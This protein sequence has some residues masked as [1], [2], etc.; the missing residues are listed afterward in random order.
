MYIAAGSALIVLASVSACSGAS[1]TL[2][3][4]KNGAPAPTPSA[5]PSTPY[6]SGYTFGQA[7]VVTG[8]PEALNMDPY[9]SDGNTAAQAC[10]QLA[11]VNAD[12]L[13][14]NGGG[15]GYIPADELPPG[16][17]NGAPQGQWANGCAA[18]YN[19]GGGS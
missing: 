11:F 8:S 2:G 16:S 19:A 13:E 18:G 4:A 5:A 6:G 1:S 14:V 12:T 3:G 17:G 9:I 10:Q 7:A 15:P